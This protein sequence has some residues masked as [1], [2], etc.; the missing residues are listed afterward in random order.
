M[1]LTDIITVLAIVVGPIIAV[2]V[3]RYLDDIR[4][5]RERKMAI[6]RNLMR[7]RKARL[8]PDHVGSLNLVEIEFHDVPT[9]VGAWKVHMDH[10]NLKLPDDV[11]GPVI[12]EWSR[13]QDRNL[14]KLLSA[15]AAELGFKKMEQLDIFDGGYSPRGWANIEDQQAVIRS[16]TID[17]L[18]GNRALPMTNAV[19]P[20][21]NSPYPPAPE[22]DPIP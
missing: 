14:T 18:Q 3:T 22:A 1:A 17:L 6:F 8:S 4:F 7:T 5:N 13:V 12:D 2:V 16:L 10:L 19:K 15:L 11:S 20:Q 9:V 21:P